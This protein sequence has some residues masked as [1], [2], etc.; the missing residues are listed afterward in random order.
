[1]SPTSPGANTRANRTR[2]LIDEKL[3]YKIIAP[4]FQ[5]SIIPGARQHTTASKNSFNFNML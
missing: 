1:M 3:P 4:T 2:K 5:Y